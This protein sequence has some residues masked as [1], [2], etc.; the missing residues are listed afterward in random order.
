MVPRSFESSG[1]RKS[2][3]AI[4]SRDASNS[5][6]SACRRSLRGPNSSSAPRCPHRA[7]GRQRQTHHAPTRQPRRNSG[8]PINGGPA[9]Q[10]GK[11]LWLPDG[12]KLPDSGVRGSEDSHRLAPGAA[13]PHQPMPLPLEF[14]WA[15]ELGKVK[16]AKAVKRSPRTLVL[17]AS[18]Q[19]TMRNRLKRTD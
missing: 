16:R 6:R 3:G 1:G 14:W 7:A 4:C 11:R 19:S 2:N 5:A 10:R 13:R 17:I 12:P 8:H 18:R 15:A 9:H